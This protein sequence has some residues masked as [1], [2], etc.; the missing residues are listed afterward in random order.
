MKKKRMIGERLK[1]NRIWVKKN[2]LLFRQVA[3]FVRYSYRLYTEASHPTTVCAAGAGEWLEKRRVI[4][5][6]G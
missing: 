6:S 2:S 4:S 1:R 5:C 3:Y